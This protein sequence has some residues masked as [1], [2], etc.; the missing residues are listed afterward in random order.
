MLNGVEDIAEM[1][2]LLYACLYWTIILSPVDIQCDLIERKLF[3]LLPP[4]LT[5]VFVCSG[6]KAKK[7]E[8]GQSMEERRLDFDEEV[9][10]YLTQALKAQQSSSQIDCM[11]NY[12]EELLLKVKIGG[13]L[14]AKAACNKN[15]QGVF[16][17]CG[18]QN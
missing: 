1:A 6:F 17:N 10:A 15:A 16:L 8:Q 13:L 9:R 3:G 11:I 7:S 4:S 12:L 5:L 2:Y 18:Y 14:P